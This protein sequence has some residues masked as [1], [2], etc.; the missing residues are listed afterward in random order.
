LDFFGEGL[1]DLLTDLPLGA[2]GSSEATSL[3]EFVV[4]KASSSSSID[5]DEFVPDDFEMGDS[6]SVN[7]TSFS[8]STAEVKLI[9]ASWVRVCSLLTCVPLAGVS[10]VV[11]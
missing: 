7:T 5:N 1:L 8:F 9:D 3:A 2:G 4:I 11:A 10:S 6:G